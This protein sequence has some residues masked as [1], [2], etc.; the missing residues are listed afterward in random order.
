MLDIKFIRE[1]KEQVKQAVEK[2]GMSINVDH[3][4]QVDEKKTL[5]L[6]SFVEQKIAEQKKELM[7]FLP[8]DALYP[9]KEVLE[10]TELFL[11]QNEIDKTLVRLNQAEGKLLEMQ[12]LVEQGNMDLAQRLFVRYETQMKNIG[13]EL[14]EENYKSF[15]QKLIV[16]FDKQIQQMKVLTVLEQS[17]DGS[18][19]ELLSRIR[20]DLLLRLRS[21]VRSPYHLLPQYLVVKLKSLLAIYLDQHIDDKEFVYSLNQLLILH[22]EK[23][24]LI[25]ANTN[26]ETVDLKNTDSVKAIEGESVPDT[27]KKDQPANTQVDPQIQPS[28]LQIQ[29]VIPTQPEIP[30][31]ADLLD[32]LNP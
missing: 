29:P 16:I 21:V 25:P 28:P 32:G 19:R 31:H 8:G 1:H 27:S 7:T 15:Q 10:E 17:F 5:A 20:H 3:L 22:G 24:L 2:K 30:I 23:S 12:D 13:F 26:T 18:T 9:A 4:L 6:H 11:Y 14:D